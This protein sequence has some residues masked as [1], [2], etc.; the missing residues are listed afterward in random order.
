M[1][2]RAAAVVAAAVVLAACGTVRTPGQ[3]LHS[4]SV[5]SGFG[6]AATTLHGDAVS[7]ARV[8]RGPDPTA[9][10]LHLVC[11]VLLVDSEAAN[12]SLPTPVD[13]V[14]HL[15]S[16]AYGSLGAAAHLCYGAAG[17]AGR[18]AAVVELQ[19]AVAQ[20]AEGR[21]AVAALSG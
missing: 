1:I 18:R 20:L 12:A 8:L 13:Q 21:A 14:T 19:R 7:V 9:K 6:S 17:A 3:A 4:W 15:L 11:A 16:R 5:E 10:L 2:R